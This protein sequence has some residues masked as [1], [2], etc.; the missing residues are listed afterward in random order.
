MSR[1]LVVAGHALVRHRQERDRP[2]VARFDESGTVQQPTPAGI[3]RA[4]C[5]CGAMSEVVGGIDA[6]RSWHTRHKEELAAVPWSDAATAARVK[7][8]GT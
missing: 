8:E 6:R 5:E 7:E 1:S 2:T 3:G 4:K